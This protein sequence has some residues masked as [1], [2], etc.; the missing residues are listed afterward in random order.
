MDVLR[1]MVAARGDAGG[2]P[3]LVA[4]GEFAQP[5]DLMQLL[6]SLSEAQ[7]MEVSA[8]ALLGSGQFT[9]DQWPQVLAEVR[10]APESA[11]SLAAVPLLG[12]YLLEALIELGYPCDEPRG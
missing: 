7:L 1:I 2:V 5:L 6:S 8:L 3:M 11:D 12:D 9:A 10:A 4:G